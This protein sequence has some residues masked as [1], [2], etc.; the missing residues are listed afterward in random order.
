MADRPVGRHPIRAR[1]HGGGE[2]RHGRGVGAHI[3]ALVVEERIIDGE[4]MPRCVDRGADAMRLLA[5]VIGGDQV[6][7]P[8][9]DPL[10]RA[11]EGEGG[12]ADQQILGIE[13]A[14]NTEAAADVAFV[15]L[16]ARRCAAQHAGDLVAVPVRH[17][18]GAMEFQHV[19]R[20]VVSR[21]RATGL[22][23]NAGMAADREVEHDDSV[24]GTKC[25]VHVSVFLVH[26]CRLGPSTGR[27]F[28]WFLIGPQQWRQFFMLRP[29]PD[30]RHPP[31]RRDHQQRRR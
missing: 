26:D 5:R 3:G 25:R 22:Q 4:D 18:G 11:A 21:D 20:A 2:V 30:R 9:L 8:I 29:P 17:L 31:P 12:D 27:E 24:R 1:Q 15:K 16:H 10:H 14:A 28:T 13:L 7:A 6:L 19:A 23:R